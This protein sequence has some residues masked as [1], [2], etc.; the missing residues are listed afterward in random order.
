MAA[1]GLQT[2][3]CIDEDAQDFFALPE[4]P[5]SGRSFGANS[6]GG[7]VFD[8]GMSLHKKV[9]QAADL[10]LERAGFFDPTA[11][12]RRTENPYA[13]PI[14]R[15]RAGTPRLTAPLSRAIRERSTASIPSAP[16][17]PKSA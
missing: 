6:A 17:S 5:G 13:S 4:A 15:G 8:A 1:S 2:E 11:S 7:A 3:T 9:L 14:S 10:L 16:T 12:S